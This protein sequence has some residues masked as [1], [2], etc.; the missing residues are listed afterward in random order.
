MN[1][2]HMIAGYVPPKTWMPPTFVIACCELRGSPIHTTA[3][4]WGV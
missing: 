1:F 2:C 3:V 4:S